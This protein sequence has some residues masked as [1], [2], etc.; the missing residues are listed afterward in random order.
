MHG[1]HRQRLRVPRLDVLD[2]LQIRFGTARTSPPGRSFTIVKSTEDEQQAPA[3]QPE[4]QHQPICTFLAVC[5]NA[6]SQLHRFCS[7]WDPSL[8]RTRPVSGSNLCVVLPPAASTGRQGTRRMLLKRHLALTKSSSSLQSVT[9]ILT[10]SLQTAHS[11]LSQKLQP[12]CAHCAQ[13]AEAG[14]G[15]QRPDNRQLGIYAT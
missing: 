5:S 2:H 7:H 15:E 14:T 4:F 1:A 13:P 3:G 12:P 11:G 8:E 9:S 10:S 6:E